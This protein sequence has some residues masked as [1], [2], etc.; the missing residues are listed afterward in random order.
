MFARSIK[1]FRSFLAPVLTDRSGVAAVF[2]AVALVPLIGAV[3]L[4][5]ELPRSAIC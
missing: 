1:A 5:I 3:G 4:A 2:M